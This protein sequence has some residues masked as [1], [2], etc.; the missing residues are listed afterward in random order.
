MRRQHVTRFGRSTL[1]TLAIA[2]GAVVLTAGPASADTTHPFLGD[3]TLSGGVSGANVA[4]V[5][6]DGN[7]LVWLDGQHALAKFDLAGNPVNF[8]ALGTNMIDGKGNNDC[9]ATPSDCDQIPV[10]DGFPG[11]GGTGQT[12]YDSGVLAAVDNS[13]GPADG[14]IYV[15]NNNNING[16]PRQNSQTDVFNPAGEFIGRVNLS[17]LRPFPDRGGKEGIAVSPNGTLIL[18]EENGFFF[19]TYAAMVVPVDGDPAHDQFAGEFFSPCADT[20]CQGAKWAFRNSVLSRNYMYTPGNYYDKGSAWVKIPI[21]ES[22]HPRTDEPSLPVNLEPGNLV[23]GN[24]G[25]ALTGNQSYT[26]GMVDPLTENVFIGLSG[27]NIQEWTEDNHQVGPSFGDGHI[28]GTQ[29]VLMMAI[30]RSGGPNDGHIYTGGIS[31]S[32]NKIAVFGDPIHIPDLSNE[33]A[34]AGHTTAHVSVDIGLDGGPQV[35]TCRVDY[36]FDTNYGFSKS[37]AEPTPYTTAGQATADLSGLSIEQDYH[38]RFVVGTANGPAVG[39]DRTFRTHAVLGVTTEPATNVGKTGADLNGSLNPD[40]IEPT[41]YQ[42]EYGID[43]SYTETTPLET[44]PSGNTQV[45]VPAVTVGG[46][47]SGR[48]YHFRLVASNALGVTHGP[49]Q[50]VVIPAAP[51]LISIT[52]SNITATSADIG[53]RINDYDSAATYHFDYGRSLD[54][55]SSTPVTDLPASGEEQPVTFFLSGLEP[56][57][58]YHFRLIATNAWGT[59]TSSDSP[60]DFLPPDCPNSHVRQLTNANYLPDCRAYELVS[61]E[62]A[63]NVSLFPGG[64]TVNLGTGFFQGDPEFTVAP[65]NAFGMATSPARFGFY[66]GEGSITGLHPPNDLA[67]R[68]VSTRTNTGWVTTYPGRQGDETTLVVRPT[69]DLGMDT[70]LDY[71]PKEELALFGGDQPPGSRAPYVWDISGKSLGRWPTNLNTVPD[72]EKFVGD[73]L[74]SPDFSHYFFSSRD[75]SFAPGG[76]LGT[77]GSAYDNDVTN[78]TMTV[79][80]KLPSGDPI[81]QEPINAGDETNF[82]DL[83][84]SSLDG[85]HILMSPPSEPVCPDYRYCPPTEPVHLFMRVDGAVTYDVS[86][87]KLVRYVG[88]TR[89]GDE[90]LFTSPDQ[91]LPA[92]EDGSVDMYMWSEDS[93]GLTIISQGNGK[94]DTDGCNAG[95][96]ERCDVRPVNPDRPLLDNTFASGNG[97]VYFYSPEQLDSSNPGINNQRNLYVFRNGQPQYV[98]TFDAGTEVDRMQVSPDD[99]HMAFLTRSRMTHYDNQGW[100]EM[101]TWDPGTGAIQCTSCIPTGEPPILSHVDPCFQC[102]TKTK[103]VDASESG[104]FM[105]DDGRVA[106]STTDAL[107]PRDT[108]RTIDVY[109]FAGNRPQL[110]SRGTGDRVK[111]GGR[112]FYPGL[113]TGFEGFS[114]D[115]TDLYFSTFDTLVPQDRNGSFVKFYDARTGGGF[116]ATPPPL[117]CSAADE[118]HGDS[119]APPPHSAVGTGGD[120]G[121]GGNLQPVRKKRKGRHHRKKSTH[122]KKHGRRHH[123]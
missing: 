81:P 104:P 45:E 79:I 30:D 65:P 64:V 115:G 36:G 47:Q 105:T 42:F 119:S 87:G 13:G 20:S 83:I 121:D 52:A 11:F 62:E 116:P 43:T 111:A 38:Y 95:W 114:T 71:R 28:G 63:G 22:H 9:P 85:S 122:V 53:A 103:D 35:D 72:G 51:S 44:A 75:Q 70:C 113:N 34:Q 17:G 3:I 101:Y 55:G 96:T 14:Y 98:S 40:G 78:A 49:D 5:D 58:T 109:E 26:T 69:C 86:Q 120:L 73:S 31:A 108:N 12:A 90:V 54:Y 80:S 8:S 107:V 123:G 4:G 10:I 88:M 92:D 118:C 25:A 48:V 59:T 102:T 66:G 61:P 76:T 2:V 84:A 50:T 18:S 100:E 117:P 110:I 68:Y 112:L 16:E 99:S 37:C 1:A 97:D 93:G 32:G 39:S 29:G 77:P 57:V 27:V 89:S 46:L 6:D 106:F 19:G 94:G 41:R 91:L 82:I 33:A 23:F 7:L 21:S 67:D 24:G 15:Q 56:G 74:P 60:I